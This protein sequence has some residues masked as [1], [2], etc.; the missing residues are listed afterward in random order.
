[1]QGATMMERINNVL[2][3]T[4]HVLL[5]MMD[6]HVL[7]VLVYQLDNLVH[8]SARVIQ[9]TMTMDQTLPV[10]HVNIHV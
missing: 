3:V 10:F 8:Q 6:Y 7:L 2:Y 9:D 4:I 5:V 1:M